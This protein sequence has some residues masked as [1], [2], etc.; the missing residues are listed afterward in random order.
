M[1]LLLMGVA[2]SGKT[3]VGQI[4]AQK[5]QWQF[6][7]ADD[8]H[9]PGNIAKMAAGIPLTDDDRAPW[10]AAL[11]SALNAW[12]VEH[13]NVVLACSA[14]KETYR[15]QLLTD[16]AVRLVYL[17]GSYELILSRLQ[18]RGHHYMKPEMLRSQF[19]TLEE[20]HSA[21]IVPIN[22]PPDT[23]ADEIIAKL[24]VTSGTVLS[25]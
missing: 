22:A 9:S 12:I 25:R 1:I 20:P 15:A 8:Y 21:I 4:L 7:D 23:I 13:T 3:T 24:Q 18:A 19:E 10:L 11:A 5:L 16:P 6:A 2:G 14:L 17:K